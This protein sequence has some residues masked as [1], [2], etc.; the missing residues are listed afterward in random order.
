MNFVLTLALKGNIMKKNLQGIRLLII[1]DE[2]LVAMFIEDIL[3]E[4]GC[5]TVDILTS[6]PDAVSRVDG[7]NF[8]AVILD[9]NLG[10]ERTY[11]LAERLIEKHIPFIFSTGYGVSGIPDNL[12]NVPIIQKPFQKSDL[13]NALHVALQ[14]E[15]LS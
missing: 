1:E 5:E 13:E 2:A 4:M 9:V 14:H 11:S 6:L 3:S 15:T 7:V 12:H 8:D 10:G